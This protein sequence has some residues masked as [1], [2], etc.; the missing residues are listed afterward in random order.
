MK[1]STIKLIFIILSIC[2]LPV[3]G[4]ADSVNTSD[5]LNV[6][7]ALSDTL[8]QGA[9]PSVTHLPQELKLGFSLVS[10][11]RGL[12]GMVVLL[13][14]SYLLSMNR[15]AVDWKVVFTGLA[16]QIFLAIGVLYIPAI[17]MIFEVGGRI[18]VEILNFTKAGSEFL[19]GNLLDANSFGFIF[20][21]PII[22][23]Q[24]L[25]FLAPGLEKSE[26]KW[27]FITIPIA[28]LLFVGGAAFAYFVML[29]VAIPYLINF[30]G[31]P[32]TPR[33]LSYVK[34][35]TN[36]IFWLAVGF[37]L[38]I[39]VFALAKFR[40]VTPKTLLKQWRIAIVL[41]AVM[42]AAITPTID[43]VNM[44]ILMLPLFLLYLLS[45]LF[46]FIAIR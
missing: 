42:A 41:I 17:R 32:T 43:P 25:M 16:I 8:V 26:K 11:L 4:M 23:S 36:L 46:A 22:L 34:F 19:L 35:T 40:L 20:A 31:V 44:A 5:T 28:T 15:K 24:L 9:N 18:F 21:F 3:A 2:V 38:P 13:A 29:P 1:S 14:I 33:L 27:I 7:R 12:L 39:V 10:V 37:E 30:L 6:H 45:I